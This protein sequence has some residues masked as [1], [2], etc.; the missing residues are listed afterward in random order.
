[1]AVVGHPD[2]LRAWLRAHLAE[3]A[4]AVREQFGAHAV[5]IGT[6]AGGG[7]TLRVYIEPGGGELDRAA[8][9]GGTEAPAILCFPVPGRTEPARVPV[10]VVQ[11]PRAAIE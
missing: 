9:A 2:D 5:G 3:N 6:A 11:S 4:A 10:E 1:M 7:P 8:S